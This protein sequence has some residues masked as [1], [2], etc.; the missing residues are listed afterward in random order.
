VNFPVINAI[1]LEDVLELGSS[2]SHHDVR[3]PERRRCLTVKVS[4]VQEIHSVDD[5]AL[6]SGR[7][8]LKHA[9]AVRDAYVFL[10]DIVAGAA[11]HIIAIGP[12]GG[13]G[14][15]GK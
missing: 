7:L 2:G 5:E 1:V 3:C 10:N 14:I 6:F 9:C 13:T 15:I 11:R 8:P 12:N 4:V